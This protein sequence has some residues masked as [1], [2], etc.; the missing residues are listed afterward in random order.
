MSKI[1][2]RFDSVELNKKQ[3]FIV[4]EI[5]E[6]VKNLELEIETFV[7]NP[8]YKALCLTKLEELAMFAIKGVS[9]N[10]N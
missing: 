1:I 8:R 6:A 7:I 2:G 10:E 4:G 5:K 3:L 9:R